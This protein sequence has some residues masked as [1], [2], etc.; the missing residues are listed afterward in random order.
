[1]IADNKL[2]GCSNKKM[3]R[4]KE[5]MVDEIVGGRSLVVD[6]M[7]GLG[8]Q[9]FILA[10]GLAYAI[11]TDRTL[12][13]DEEATHTMGCADRTTY[14]KTFFKRFLQHNRVRGVSSEQYAFLVKNA[15]LY[16]E[17]KFHYGAIP[18]FSS[19]IVRLS[20]YFQS[21]L[22]FA[23][24]EGTILDTFAAH[25]GEGGGKVRV[26]KPFASAFGKFLTLLREHD[27]IDK[28]NQGLLVSMHVRRGDFLKLEDTHPTLPRRYYEAAFE[29]IIRDLVVAPDIK[30][31]GSVAIIVFSDDPEWCRQS[32]LVK[33]LGERDTCSACIVMDG[34]YSDVDSM[35]LMSERWLFAAHIIANS[36]F[37][38]WGAYLSWLASGKKCPVAAPGRWFGPNGPKRHSI[39]PPTWHT[40]QL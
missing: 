29:R 23:N 22:Y 28:Y 30:D 26:E 16:K 38:W 5:S 19:Q 14:W 21:P 11:R 20:G 15:V 24:C 6:L 33:A 31:Q 2:V 25:E 12:Y 8:N 36:S 37:S 40:L 34:A 32:N 27:S 3:N 9:C 1:M 17:S 4:G 13:V 35:W 10:A 18:L 39:L 7:G